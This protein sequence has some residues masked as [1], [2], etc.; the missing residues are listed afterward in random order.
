MGI[1]DGREEEVEDGVGKEVWV[2][3]R[4]EGEGEDI[5]VYVGIGKHCSLGVLQYVTVVQA[6]VVTKGTHPATP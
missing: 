6:A 4:E 5:A 3:G 2:W 1:C